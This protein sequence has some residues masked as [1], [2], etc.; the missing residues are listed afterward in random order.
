MALDSEIADADVTL[1]SNGE[2]QVTAIQ[3][4]VSLLSLNLTD[5]IEND[6]R[7]WT[8]HT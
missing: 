7:V 8:G 2:I 5:K 4:G 6:L 3:G 1:G